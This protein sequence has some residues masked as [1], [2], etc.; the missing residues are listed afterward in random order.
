MPF[1]LGF[2]YPIRCLQMAASNHHL[3][4]GNVNIIQNEHLFKNYL[5]TCNVISGSSL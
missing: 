1:S 4:T 5:H 2:S 3:A